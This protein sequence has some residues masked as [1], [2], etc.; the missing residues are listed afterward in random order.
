V[1]GY[2]DGRGGYT[3]VMHDPNESVT[4]E[5]PGDE[6]AHGPRGGNSGRSLP[7]GVD[8]DAGYASDDWDLGEEDQPSDRHDQQ[9]PQVAREVREAVKRADGP[10][11]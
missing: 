7:P 1:T 10:L 6:R 4:P 11:G 5:G 8:L 9:W 3:P 2:R